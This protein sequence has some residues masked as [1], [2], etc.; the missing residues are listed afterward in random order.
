MG[1]NLLIPLRLAFIIIANA[2]YHLPSMNNMNVIR[3]FS[4][5][6]FFRKCLTKMTCQ[7]DDIP[8]KIIFFTLQFHVPKW[9]LDAYIYSH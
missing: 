7:L 3:K 8:Q 9:M 4:T 6:L 5:R 2:L 1:L